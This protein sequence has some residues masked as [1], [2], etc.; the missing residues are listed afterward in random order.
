MKIAILI[1]SFFCLINN[2]QAKEYQWK[3]LDVA[4]GDTIKVEIPGLEEMHTSVRVRN[5]DT[6]EK[7]F[8]AKC[9]EEDSMGHEATNYTTMLVNN[10]RVITFSEISWDKYGGRILAKVK[11][12]GK[13][14][15]EQLISAKLARPYHGEKKQGWC[16]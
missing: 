10:S 12:D 8:R 1:F 3:V 9:L 15:A 13:D 4:D 7:G 6:P 14:L 16:K 2:V 5:I 11:L